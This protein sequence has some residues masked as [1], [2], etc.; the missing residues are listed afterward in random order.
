MDSVNNDN[1]IGDQALNILSMGDTISP[2]HDQ[3]LQDDRETISDMLRD[4][5]GGGTPFMPVVGEHTALG[6][7]E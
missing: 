2:W 1:L 3:I 6:V 4:P 5:F 7:G